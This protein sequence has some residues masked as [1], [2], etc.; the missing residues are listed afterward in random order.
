M[1]TCGCELYREIHVVVVLKNEEFV[2]YLKKL[3]YFSEGLSINA[4]GIK[5][6]H[7]DFKLGKQ[8]SII[9]LL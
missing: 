1:S 3:N 2:N 7:T 8:L 6:K 4:T 5:L 9:E